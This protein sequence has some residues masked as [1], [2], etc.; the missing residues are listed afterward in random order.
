MVCRG[1]VVIPQQATWAQLEVGAYMKDKAGVVWKVERERD[2]HFGVVN[3]AGEKHI[4]K[5]RPAKTPV[6]MLVPTESEA[7]ATLK[8][9]LGAKPEALMV[10]GERSWRVK[11]WPRDKQT[12]GFSLFDARSHLAL[13]HVGYAADIPNFKDAQE[14]HDLCHADGTTTLPHT[15]Q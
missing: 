1:Q 3:R 14:C 15:H 7:A 6:T 12:A 5:P 11:A 4:L 10:D 9:V 8:E 2:R 13:F